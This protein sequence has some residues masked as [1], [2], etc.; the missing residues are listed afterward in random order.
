MSGRDKTSSDT[1]FLANDIHKMTII[2]IKCKILLVLGAKHKLETCYEAKKTFT[3]QENITLLIKY[4][5]AYHWQ[6]SHYSPGNHHAI[7]L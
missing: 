4:L 2:P 3:T 6:E 7:H 5:G 1:T